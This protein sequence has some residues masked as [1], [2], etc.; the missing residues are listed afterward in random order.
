M[1]DKPMTASD[2]RR[3]PTITAS[4]RKRWKKAQKALW[5]PLINEAKK[6]MKRHGL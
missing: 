6:I 3:N 1:T 4:Q 5:G 2:I